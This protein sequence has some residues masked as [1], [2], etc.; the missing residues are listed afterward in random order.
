MFDNT[1]R[2]ATMTG[3][4]S[5]PHELAAKMTASWI[6]FARSGNPGLD[7]L[8]DWKSFTQSGKETMVIDNSPSLRRNLDD[9]ELASLV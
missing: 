1:D 6:S 4:G 3:G 9:K 7:G 2:A 5:G 8:T